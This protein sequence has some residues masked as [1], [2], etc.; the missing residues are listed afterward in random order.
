MFKCNGCNITKNITEFYK[1]TKSS[2]GHKTK[3][4]NCHKKQKNKFGKKNPNK[5]TAWAK[6]SRIKHKEARRS[7]AKE[8]KRTRYHS[9]MNFRLISIIRRRINSYVSNENKSYSAVDL[10]GCSVNKLIKYLESKFKPGMTWDNY[11][12]H[13][14]HIDHIRPLASFNLL[15]PIE[16]RVACNYNNLQPL[17]AEDNLKKGVK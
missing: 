13:G 17:W 16:A 5:I 15:D 12:L 3:C 7:Y 2:R 1:E 10:L 11:G 14:W 4:A 6:Q 9:D 8:Y